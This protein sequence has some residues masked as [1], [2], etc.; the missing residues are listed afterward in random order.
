MGDR[1]SK[2]EGDAGG[3]GPQWYQKPVGIIF[4]TVSAGVLLWFVTSV[5]QRSIAPSKP[6]VVIK[7]VPAEAQVE[8]QQEPPQ[9]QQPKRQRAGER[10][11]RE[12]PKPPVEEEPK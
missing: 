1:S 2:K 6:E 10:K 4:L 7:E 12:K 9:P 11:E 5:L 8:P 3:S